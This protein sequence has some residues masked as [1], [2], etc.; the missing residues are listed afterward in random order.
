MWHFTRVD[1]CSRKLCNSIFEVNTRKLGWRW[2]GWLPLLVAT[3]LRIRF[4]I[5]VHLQQS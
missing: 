3:P 5:G 2:L 1:G 4:V